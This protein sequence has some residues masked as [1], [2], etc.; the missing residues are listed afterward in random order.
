VALVALYKYTDYSF[1]L[2]IV[3]ICKKAL[4]HVL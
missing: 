4:G 3:F 2:R 1:S